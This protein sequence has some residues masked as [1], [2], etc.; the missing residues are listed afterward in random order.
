MGLAAPF[1][2]T[3]SSLGGVFFLGNDGIYVTDC[4]SQIESITND[5]LRP[6]FRGEFSDDFPPVNF[7]ADDGNPNKDIR[8]FASGQE[9]HFIYPFG[10]SDVPNVIGRF[11]L[12]YNIL[13][14]SWRQFELGITDHVIS[15]GDP[16]LGSESAFIVGTTLFNI[17]GIIT[18]PRTLILKYNNNDESSPLHDAGSVFSISVTTGGFD[19]EIPQ[20]LKE[21]GNIIVD[22]DPNGGIISV[23]PIRGDGTSATTQ[24]LT[25]TGRARYP[26][27]LGDEYDYFQSYNFTWDSSAYATLY[28]IEILFRSDQEVLKHWEIPET[29]FGLP[30][31]N[32]IR[33]G[34]FMLRSDAIINVTQTIDGV[35]HTYTIPSTSGQKR[36]MYVKFDPVRGKVFRFAL[37]SSLGFRLYGDETQLNIKPW[38]TNLGYKPIFP[39][40]APG[41][42]PFLRNEAGT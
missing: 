8:L 4:Q 39:F 13:Q 25:G 35:A 18:D 19:M 29:T 5:S 26:L 33:D 27:S 37:D 34:Y 30:G 17:S 3:V 31:W 38:N 16:M 22:A 32:H 10:S 6:I 21:F 11:H 2:L 23:T 14:K 12:V 36:K 20:T 15:A 9:L 41:Y 24:T 40:G 7:I 42:A 1:A 28:N